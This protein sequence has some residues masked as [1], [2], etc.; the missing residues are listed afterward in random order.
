MC[1]FPES[2]KM[3]PSLGA[4]GTDEET[5]RADLRRGKKSV[6][7]FMACFRHNQGNIGDSEKSKCVYFCYLKRERRIRPRTRTDGSIHEGGL[8]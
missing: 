4:L 1:T 3:A 6:A 5:W 8:P 2:H 7:P